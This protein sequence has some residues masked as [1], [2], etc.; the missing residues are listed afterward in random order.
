MNRSEK[1]AKSRRLDQ[2]PDKLV[3]WERPALWLLA[4]CLG[5]TLF[6]WPFIPSGSPWSGENQYLFLFAAWG[7]IIVI[8]SLIAAG[9]P[10]FRP[11]G[12][13]SDRD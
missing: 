6:S 10:P 2:P 9:L 5:M 12:G 7:F 11:G 3:L 8:I 1:K 4:F 13:R